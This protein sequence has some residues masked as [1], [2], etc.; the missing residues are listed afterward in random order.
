MCCLQVYSPVPSAPFPHPDCRATSLHAGPC[1]GG[2]PHRKPRLAGRL[3]CATGCVVGCGAGR[4]G[5][6]AAAGSGDRGSS[7]TVYSTPDAPVAHAA[8]RT[9]LRWAVSLFQLLWAGG[10]GEPRTSASGGQRTAMAR[11]SAGRLGRTLLGLPQVRGLAGAGA[12][13]PRHCAGPAPPTRCRLPP[14]HRAARR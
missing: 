14:A 7:S 6:G 8:P 10:G 1:R 9:L 13:R 3:N 2:E 12:G 4:L 5:C 11:Y